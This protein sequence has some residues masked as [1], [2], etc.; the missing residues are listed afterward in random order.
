MGTTR[1]YLAQYPKQG[2]LSKDCT[3]NSIQATYLE[4]LRKAQALELQNK[5]TAFLQAQAKATDLL[6]ELDQLALGEV[7]L[8]GAELSAYGFQDVSLDPILRTLP[9]GQSKP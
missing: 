2:T 4:N 7:D 9:I 1:A 6:S 5:V 8:L 3:F